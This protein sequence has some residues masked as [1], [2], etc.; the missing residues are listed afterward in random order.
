[1]GCLPN[2]PCAVGVVVFNALTMF[3]L[4]NQLLLKIYQ[5]LAIIVTIK[6]L[7]LVTFEDP[8]LIKT[9]TPCG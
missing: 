1:M 4:D 7:K 6:P 3:R 9:N 8:S 5:Q 2:A